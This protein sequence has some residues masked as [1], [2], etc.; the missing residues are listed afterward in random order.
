MRVKFEKGKQREFI[1]KVLEN[2]NC[3]SLRE[4]IS[5]GISTNYSSLKNYFIEEY[6]LPEELFNEL[7]ELSLINKSDF[8]FELVKDNWGQV[9]GGKVRFK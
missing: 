8:D 3:P 2:L 6:L 1:K 9:K 4:L 5:R 7:V